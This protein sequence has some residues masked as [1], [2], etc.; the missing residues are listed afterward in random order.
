MLGVRWND[1]RGPENLGGTAGTTLWA[2]ERFHTAQTTIS[3]ATITARG[4]FRRC[5]N[6]RDRVTD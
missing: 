3:D 2:L 1:R 5:T 6:R 4:I